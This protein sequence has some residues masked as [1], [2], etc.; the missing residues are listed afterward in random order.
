MDSV[1]REECHELGMK[2]IDKV[3][4]ISEQSE[5]A[6][7]AIQLDYVDQ[8][9]AAGYEATFGGPLAT[10]H[11]VI[12]YEGLHRALNCLMEEMRDKR[13]ELKVMA[14]GRWSGPHSLARGPCER[15]V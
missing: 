4:V 7:E 1:L 3:M 15:P 2:N 8:H 14:D 13:M 10:V 11:S 12:D 9:G 5:N 6:S